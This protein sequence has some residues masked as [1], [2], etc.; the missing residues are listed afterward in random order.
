MPAEL[1]ETGGEILC[2]MIQQDKRSTYNVTLR[3]VRE[4]IVAAE[5]QQV[6][7]ILNGVL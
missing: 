1:M 7:Y 3:G 6:L 5:K 2:V 4:T